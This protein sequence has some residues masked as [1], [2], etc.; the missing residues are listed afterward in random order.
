[1]SGGKWRR[2]GKILLGLLVV[3]AAVVVLMVVTGI[4]A[5]RG[6][7]AKLDGGESLPGLRAP[8]SIGRDALGVP[9]IQASTRLDLSF[10]TGFLHAQE[11][12]FQMDLLRRSA[13]GE[14]AALLGPALVDYDARMR[15]HGMRGTA[16]RALSVLPASH[17]A[18]LDAYTQGVNAGLAA[19]TVRPPEYLLFRTSPKPW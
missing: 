17:R 12:F 1:M 10:A 4:A 8:V 3:A 14:L 13:A 11:R 19:L 15:I 2:F 16:E 9:S 18:V 5:L 6:S 7:L